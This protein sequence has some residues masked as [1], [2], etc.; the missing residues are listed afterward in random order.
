MGENSKI[1]WTHHTFNPWWGCTRVSPACKNCYAEAWSRRLG[2]EIWGGRSPRR[3]FSDEH[4]RQPFRW[5]RDAE[6]AGSRR[7]VFCASMADLFENRRDLD[8]WRARVWELVSATPWLDWL[9]LT[10]RPEVVRKLVPWTTVWPDNVWLGT[11]AENQHWAAKRIP[12]LL[13]LPAA[14][15]FVSCEPLL[16][17]LD[18]RPW[19]ATVSTARARLNWVIVGGESGARARPMH[20][21][22]AIG[23]R[24]QCAEYA[25][26]FHFKQWGQW[27]PAAGSRGASHPSIE[28]AAAQGQKIRLVKVG[29]HASG[30]TLDGRTWDGVPTK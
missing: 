8:A 11:T 25:V 17:P 2:L 19:L 24:D 14:I 5:N 30:R 16:G 26:P 18:L 4:W 12:A 7:R 13:D 15:H 20:P 23:L 3:L 9:L 22:W 10:K 21:E 29:K 1:E 6:A 28:L 27:S